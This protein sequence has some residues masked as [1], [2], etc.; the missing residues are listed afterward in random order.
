[1]TPKNLDDKIFDAMLDVAAEEILEERLNEWE[2]LDAE[3][4]VFSPEF[5]QKM[6]R[7]LRQSAHEVRARKTRRVLRRVAAVAAIFMVAGFVLTMSVS[8]IRVKVLN[9]IIEYADTHYGINFG[10]TAGESGVNVAYVYPGY[11]PAGYETIE[12]DS[13]TSMWKNIVYNNKETGDSLAFL[14]ILKLEGTTHTFDSEHTDAP[15]ETTYKGKRLLIFTSNTEGYASFVIWESET[16]FYE[17]SA[18]LPVD[19]LLKVAK[20]ALE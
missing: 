12:H 9:T 17:V 10:E 18:C 5:E 19:E 8:A 4:H 3:P 13:E 15:Y 20:S 1:M 6:K 7:L 14:Q 11:I 16:V 2:T